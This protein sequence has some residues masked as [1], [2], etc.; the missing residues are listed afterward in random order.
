MHFIE[1][2]DKM[3]NIA[4]PF[5]SFS[6]CFTTSTIIISLLSKAMAFPS[7]KPPSSSSSSSSSPTPSI[8]WSNCTAQDPPGV[9]CGQISVPLDYGNPQGD[10]ITLGMVRFNASSSS[11]LGSLIYVCCFR[12]QSHFDLANGN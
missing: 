10:K 12:I 3:K 11:R 7:P 5:S 4:F 1:L 2:I 6:Q 9:Q 8:T